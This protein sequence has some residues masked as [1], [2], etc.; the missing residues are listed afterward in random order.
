[1]ANYGKTIYYT[2]GDVIFDE[3]D[4]IILDNTTT[5]LRQFYQDKY[6]INITNLHQPLL[7]AVTKQKTEIAQRILLVPELMLMTG[8][9]EDF[10]EMRRKKISESTIKPP[11]AKIE[12]ISGLMKKLKNSQDI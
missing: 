7:V 5:N 10:D 4:S 2:V 3:M 8:I 1:M 11:A 12:E 6:K 9:P